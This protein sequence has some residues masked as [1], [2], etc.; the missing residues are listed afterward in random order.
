MKTYRLLIVLVIFSLVLACK[1][2]QKEGDDKKKPE[3]KDGIGNIQWPD[4]SKKGTGNFKN[5]LKE[6][7]WTLFHRE[8]GEKQG[9]GIYVND[10]QDG[11]WVFFHKNGKKSAEGA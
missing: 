3:V 11:R 6:G 4:G 2:S 5:G 9:E 1:S 7:K 8:T 10:K